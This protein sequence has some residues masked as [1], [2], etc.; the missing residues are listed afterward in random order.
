[1]G[2]YYSDM[3]PNGE[4]K[5]FDERYAKY[6][7]ERAR[8]IY[9][10]ILTNPIKFE[11]I[12]IGDKLTLYSPLKGLSK[13]RF[14]DKGKFHKIRDFF[15][16]SSGYYS[17]GKSCLSWRDEFKVYDMRRMKLN[18]SLEIEN[19]NWDEVRVN[20]PRKD[21]FNTLPRWIHIKYFEKI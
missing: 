16:V 18:S 4:D 2:H 6:R 12:N 1:M 15:N 17:E 8:E 21:Y 11:E 20:A 10:I 7:K 9:D 3:F 5:T 13:I 19:T 14:D